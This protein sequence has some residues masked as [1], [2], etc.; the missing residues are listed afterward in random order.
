MTGGRAVDLA[1]MDAQPFAGLAFDA[2]G[3]ATAMQRLLRELAGGREGP[4]FLDS[5]GGRRRGRDLAVVG[6][7]GRAEHYALGVDQRHRAVLARLQGHGD[8][9]R[10]A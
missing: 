3:E 6:G 1:D 2:A 8:V 7:L 4:G 5:R 9:K 10:N